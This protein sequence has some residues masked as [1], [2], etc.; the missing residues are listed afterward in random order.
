M[1]E[2]EDNSIIQLAVC[3]ATQNMVKPKQSEYPG[4]SPCF[5]QNDIDDM[6]DCMQIG[7]ILRGSL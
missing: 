3:A 7:F 4:G 2:Y 1:K 6:W 5:P